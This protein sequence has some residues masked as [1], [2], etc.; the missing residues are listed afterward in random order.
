MI[1]SG[2]PLLEAVKG[3]S[4]NI[5]TDDNYSYYSLVLTVLEYIAIVLT[6]AKLDT[7]HRLFKRKVFKLL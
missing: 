3:L 7:S 2:K 5:Y 1:A 4:L 6:L